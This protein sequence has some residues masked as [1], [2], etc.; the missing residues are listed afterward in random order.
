MIYPLNVHK[1][2][3]NAGKATSQDWTRFAGLLAL[4][5]IILLYFLYDFVIGL[6]IG[7][8]VS[9]F[10]ILLA[11]ATV[12]I[13][14][15][16]VF[17][18]FIFHEDEK[19]MEY[20]GQEHDTFARYVKVRKDTD[21]TLEIMRKEIA[22]FEYT[23]GSLFSVMQLKFGGNDNLRS[24]NTFFLFKQIV[25][26][27][28]EQG[29]EFRTFDLAEDFFKSSEYNN[30]ASALNKIAN[31][32]LRYT[33]VHIAD[34]MLEVSK[35]QSN[36]PTVY[37]QIIAQNSYKQDDLKLA[38]KQIML[39]LNKTK[40]AVRDAHFLDKKQLLE[41]YEQFYGMEVIDLSAMKVLEM[42]EDGNFDYSNV[43]TVAEILLS[44]GK[45]L[46]MKNDDDKSFHKFA[47]E[48]EL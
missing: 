32:D 41:F 6:L 27:L 1:E 16:Y 10:A 34:Y 26:I 14:G 33:L 28:G 30:Y 24:K 9:W 29:L 4:I 35:E 43:A 44:D 36:V 22:C 5:A 3:R 47:R 20:K 37:L 8:N 7:Q 45:R 40:T 23:N 19:M 25:H 46:K 15:Y 11:L 31:K 2:I 17:R 13:I 42:T 18:F 48:V 21:N 38:L 12:F 39:L